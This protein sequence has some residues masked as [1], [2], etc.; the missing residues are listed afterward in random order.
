MANPLFNGGAGANNPMAQLMQMLSGGVNPQQL[1]QTMLSQ[2]PQL[3]QA[4]TQMQGMARQSGMS[5]EQYAI[6]LAKSQG[7]SEEQVRQLYSQINR[8][9]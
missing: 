3:S 8:R 9:R 5:A 1:A 7:I 2:N 4:L 6:S